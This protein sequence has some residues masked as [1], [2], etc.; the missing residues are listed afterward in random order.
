MHLGLTASCICF[1]CGKQPDTA[2][3]CSVLLR[4]QI[5]PRNTSALCWL[6][7]FQIIHSIS[8]RADRSQSWRRPDEI[9]DQQDRHHDARTD[10]PEDWRGTRV[11]ISNMP[12]TAQRRDVEQLFEKENIKMSV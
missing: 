4:P 10:K 2:S 8:M 6:L 5:D 7:E 3:R 11:Y 9:A 1:L 12:Y